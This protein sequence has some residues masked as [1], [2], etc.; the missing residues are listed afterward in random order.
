M[1]SDE[2]SRLILVDENIPQPEVYFGRLGR[3][4]QFAGRSLAAS[5]LR[6]ASALIVRSITQVNE[7]LLTGSAVNFVGSCTIGTDHVDTKWLLENNISFA[8]APGCNANSVV[9]YVLTALAKLNVNWQGARIGIIGCGNVGG[10]LY[11]RLEALGVK[12]VGYDPLIEQNRYPNLTTL[13]D[14]LASDVVCVHTPH[15]TD[16]PFP[17]FHLLGADQLAQLKPN[18]VLINAGRGPSIDNKALLQFKQERPDLRL[19]LDV[20]EQEPW[21]DPRLLQLVDVGTP[22]IAGYSFDGKLRGTQIIYAA[23]CKAWGA[24][25]EISADVAVESL[26]YNDQILTQL[27][28]AD[29]QILRAQLLCAYDLS[30]DDTRLRAMVKAATNDVELRVGFDRLRKV[31]PQRREFNFAAPIAANLSESVKQHLRA[32]GFPGSAK[33]NF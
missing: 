10:L 7:S 30:G 18:A 8:N 9:E 13:D 21:L 12:P 14:V 15:T 23:L 33:D 17:S 16:G 26:I 31:Y 11:R 4:Q 2:T 28:A 1:S 3:V 32:L 29:W 20:W 27:N 22:H 6:D 24:Q 5:D 25:Q 19:V